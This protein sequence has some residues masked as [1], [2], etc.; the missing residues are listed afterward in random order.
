M[1][2]GV[3][4]IGAATR[5]RMCI[6]PGVKNSYRAALTCMRNIYIYIFHID[7]WPMTKHITTYIYVYTVSY[8]YTNISNLLYYACCASRYQLCQLR[9]SLSSARVVEIVDMRR[10]LLEPRPR[11]LP[12]LEPLS[13]VNLNLRTLSF[14]RE[15]EVQRQQHT[16]S[17]SVPGMQEL[18]GIS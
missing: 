1:W 17:D 15:A 4:N 13:S 3:C 18:C 14:G 9:V 7:M 12:P 8:T 16:P 6:R 2:L 11:W 5:Y 10:R